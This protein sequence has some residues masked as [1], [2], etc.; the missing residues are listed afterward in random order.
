MFD[1]ENRG[2][3][4]EKKIKTLSNGENTVVRHVC[5]NGPEFH[6]TVT[7]SAIITFPP[8]PT[9]VKIRENVV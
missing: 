4:I 7:M 3:R 6:E 1:G 9:T 5:R 2:V 8:F